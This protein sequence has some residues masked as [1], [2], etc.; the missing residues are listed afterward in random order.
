MTRAEVLQ[1]IT[2]RCFYHELS[3]ALDNATAGVEGEGVLL[4]TFD[5]VCPLME[6]LAREIA[7][8]SD[9]ES[10]HQECLRLAELF[11]RVS[12]SFHEDKGVATTIWWTS[13]ALYRAMEDL[14]SM[15][16]PDARAQLLTNATKSN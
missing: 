6:T 13:I 11:R 16:S 15:T 12:E 3:V 4:A 2:L 10:E 1:T 8:S 9:P 14:A 7:E 5:R